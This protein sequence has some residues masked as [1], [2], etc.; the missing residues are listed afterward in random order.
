MKRLLAILLVCAT[1]GLPIAVA[2]PVALPAVENVGSGA[3]VKGGDGRIYFTAGGETA[4]FHVYSI[5]GQLLRTVRVSADGRASVDM[6]KGFYVVRYNSSWSRK[7]V[8]K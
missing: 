7:V 5:T 8:V 6:P 3:S 4:V 2:A 1:L